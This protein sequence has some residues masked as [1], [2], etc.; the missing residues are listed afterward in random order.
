LL[1]LLSGCAHPRNWQAINAYYRYDFAEAA[2]ALRDDAARNNDDVLLN[3]LR[4]GLAAMAA[5][6]DAEAERAL[7]AAF[8]WLSTAGLNQ[9]RTT[10]AILVSESLRIWKGE[11]FEQ[12]LAYYWIA[13]FY[14]TLGDWE[15]VRAAAANA[16][17]RLTDFGADQDMESLTR[18]AA[19]DPAFLDRGYS[20]VDTNFALGFLMQAIG[21]NL[22][23]AAG[24]D[25]QLDAALT[26]DPALRPIADVLRSGA[27]D[28]LLLVDYGKGPTKI[29][30]GPDDALVH[31]VPQERHHGLLLVHADGV[32]VA[33]ALPVCN[34]DALAVDHRWNNLEDVRQARSAI[35]NLL[36]AGG[37]IAATSGAWNG[38]EGTFYAGIGMIL[39]GALLRA[40]ARADDRHLE[41]A[42]QS[43]YVVPMELASPC[44][45]EVAVEGDPGSGVILRDFAPGSRGSPRAVYLRMHGPD[46][47]P[48][49]PPPGASS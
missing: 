44:V 24:A 14:A 23:G 5:G 43:I 45:L 33:Q 26:I 21:S 1:L 12:A 32:Q 35:G 37:S 25:A 38:S 9:D 29:T 40:S 31:F 17:F 27:W 16:L 10:A 41:F 11:P 3:N 8:N 46:S 34:V 39:A 48:R 4:L 30:F 28:T 19:A 18:Q 15:N 22:S 49:P 20:A 42:P 6:D 7:L 13:A 2:A 36:L 47:P